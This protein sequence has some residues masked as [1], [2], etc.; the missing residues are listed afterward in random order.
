MSIQNLDDAMLKAVAIISDKKID[1]A[2][3]ASTIQGTVIECKD[4]ANNK[5]LI[6]YQDSK[7]E[8]YGQKGIR[9]SN[10]TRVYIYVPDGKISSQ[11]KVILGSPNQLATDNIEGYNGEEFYDTGQ[12]FI[13][14]DNLKIKMVSNYTTQHFLYIKGNEQNRI[15][16]SDN[17]N[18]IIKNTNYLKLSGI[19]QT[20]LTNEQK[21]YGR[22]GI[23]ISLL[24]KNSATGD[25]EI[26]DFYFD[27]NNFEG[28][29]YQFNTS[30]HQEV[31]WP[32]DSVNF[33]E[34]HSI[35]F[36]TQ[37]FPKQ[38]VPVPELEEDWASADILI[39]DFSIN[40]SYQLNEAERT[41]V[42]VI[43]K[44]PN[45]STFGEKADDKD[46]RL[47]EAEL[48]VSM[49]KVDS[50]DPNLKVYWFK[51]DASI[52]STS[53]Y[54]STIGGLGWKCLNEHV[55]QLNIIDEGTQNERTIKEETPQLIPS[56]SIEIPLLEVKYSQQTLFRCII[57]YG[58]KKYSRDFTILNKGAQ[59]EVTLESSEGTS[60]KYSAGN[61][62]LTCR[63]FSTEKGQKQEVTDDPS[64]VYRWQVRNNQ[65]VTTVLKENTDYDIR[66]K[67]AHELMGFLW[68]ERRETNQWQD[69]MDPD[70]ENISLDTKA[71]RIECYQQ[72]S[73]KLPSEEG[74]V[75]LKY[76]YFYEK[77]QSILDWYDKHKQQVQGNVLYNVDLHQITKQSTFWCS[78]YKQDTQ[79]QEIKYL[80]GTA[81]ITIENEKTPSD[82][83][84]LVINH[85]EQ[86]FLYD[87][88]GMSLHSAAID[89]PYEIFDLTYTLYYNGR[90]IESQDLKNGV[91]PIWK[92]PK[93][94]TMLII[95]N[96]NISLAQTDNFYIYKGLET[97]PID[98]NNTY[99]S[100][101][102]NND[103]FL[104]LEYN[105]QLFITKTNFTFT[106]Q[107]QNGTNGT[108]YCFKI[109]LA[110]NSNNSIK[111]GII[112]IKSDENLR[113]IP[114]KFEIIPKFWY[115]GISET[116]KPNQVD[117]RILTNNLN[118][119]PVK[120][121]LNLDMSVSDINSSEVNKK[122]ELVKT[123][124]IPGEES[125]LSENINLD[126]ENLEHIIQASCTHNGYK[127]YADLPI[128]IIKTYFGDDE[129][130]NP[131]GYKVSL[132]PGSGFRYVTYRSDGTQPKYDDRLPFEV[133]ITKKN[134][135]NT[136]VEI[137]DI[138]EEEEVSNFKSERF[139]YNW[140]I[141][142]RKEED[143][144]LRLEDIKGEEN[145]KKAIPKSI[146]TKGNQVNN[147]IFISIKIKG[148]NNEETDF[149]DIHIP[150][151][152]MLNKY[153]NRALN[154]WNGT[155]IEINKTDGYIL[156]PQV[157]AGKKNTHDNGENTFTGVVLGVAATGNSEQT[158]LFAYG[159]GVRSIFLD[160]KTGNATFG[161]AGSGQIEID[162]DNDKALITSS[163]YKDY[164]Y[165]KEHS[166]PVTYDKNG[167][168]TNLKNGQ[169]M[170]IQFS[171]SDHGPHIYFGSGNFFVTKQGFMHTSSGQIAGW[172]IDQ[173]KIYKQIDSERDKTNKVTKQG[174]FA[175]INSNTESHAFSAGTI[176]T[177]GS[178]EEP[179]KKHYNFYVNYDGYLFSNRGKIA[180]WDI[181][182]DSIQKTRSDGKNVGMRSND[183]PNTNKA[184]FAGPTF[185]VTHGGFLYSEFGQ[186]AKWNI[187]EDR[188]DKILKDED[189]TYWVGISPSKTFITNKNTPTATI[190]GETRQLQNLCFW[191][192]SS[193]DISGNRLS[194]NFYVDRTGFLFSK[195]GRIG[196]W[197]IG[198]GGLY[199]DGASTYYQVDAKGNIEKDKDGNPIRLTEGVYVGADGIRLGDGFWVNPDGRIF[200]GN[201]GH[202]GQIAIANGGIEGKTW[203]IKGSGEAKFSNVTVN[204]QSFIDL[205]GL[206]SRGGSGG[207]TSIG[208]GAA[209]ANGSGLNLSPTQV[210]VSYQGE[211]M[212]LQAFVNALAE[213]IVTEKVKADKIFV[214]KTVYAHDFYISPDDSQWTGSLRSVLGSIFGRLSS[215]ES[216]LPSS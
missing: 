152:F 117:W 165:N 149:A 98:V 140:E 16:L 145:K 12:N 104:E 132:R 157:G 204:G 4:E 24:I 169:G 176:G 202:I 113:A 41:S 196:N 15:K 85:G 22:Y 106:K 17:I 28:N 108:K 49:R 21:R 63:V 208:N 44:M 48:R 34:V 33:V 158:G 74:G 193:G 171:S 31:Y 138:P 58:G 148:E 173:N 19:V 155:S 154:D 29:P 91:V 159:D 84:L 68:D 47:I 103:I 150:I 178:N 123:Q 216:K 50:S 99:N 97:L 168:P 6:Q 89:E 213:E 175:S 151:H 69:F 160:A 81:S 42:G 40:G 101:F 65:N 124:T 207:G 80:V 67:K 141:F 185:Y 131:Q 62:T 139:I 52:N 189:T 61:P 163:D 118:K 109:E 115:N 212:T 164:Y 214:G 183:S 51:Q 186:I 54:F 162:V 177:L 96:E 114:K 75:L 95:D 57:M 130:S 46:T 182:E 136:D 203:F 142:P 78:C 88:Q 79:T 172:T 116:I 55:K 192:G 190:V 126:N 93:K 210:T 188:I 191:A 23:K 215:I 184:F 13:T 174:I 10:G 209:S 129:T 8:A 105:E 94:D 45:G 205:V 27:S 107:G 198:A 125:P 73:N 11:Y 121:Y 187:Q 206:T 119:A 194:P 112:R 86:V 111:D 147:A 3:I 201:G 53:F 77:F 180:G 156:T 36:F 128:P 9:Y 82:G 64:Y 2:Q 20:N 26:Q 1:K 197:N 25:E 60:F 59:F 70:E 72:T 87:E 71:K 133:I 153:Q 30:S 122:G 43:L 127:Y 5:Y 56:I 92:V 18:G 135:L 195:F 35:S 181:T 137:S 167:I 179:T 200:A 38:T 170:Q 144:L 83:Y 32:I 211:S 37:D 76:S 7:I 120:K 166:R 14:T 143:A 199:H 90:A 161:K 100:S 39:T 102:T 146:F 110:D 66:Y 134:L